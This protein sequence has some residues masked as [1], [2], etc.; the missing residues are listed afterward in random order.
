MYIL[1][2]L[3]SKNFSFARIRVSGVQ[4]NLFQTALGAPFIQLKA[5]IKVKINLFMP[6]SIDKLI[7]TRISKRTVSG[8]IFFYQ[9]R[10]G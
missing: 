8:G 1:L 10:S 3:Y 5:R 4:P 7:R 2:L 6:F 9:P